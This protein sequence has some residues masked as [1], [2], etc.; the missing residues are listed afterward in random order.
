M[1]T[2]ALVI[3]AVGLLV[4]ADAPKED[5]KKELKKF[6][7]SWALVSG[8]QE[9]K[10]FSEDIIKSGKLTITGDKH[11]VKVGNDTIVGTHTVDPSKKP[12]AIDSLDTEGPFKGKTALGIYE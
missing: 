11:N 9:G 2:T 3:V 4:A 7:G 10:A 1:R 5:V 12:K 6:E 8:E